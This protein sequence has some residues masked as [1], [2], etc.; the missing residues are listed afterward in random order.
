MLPMFFLTYAECRLILQHFLNICLGV[1]AQGLVSEIGPEHQRQETR[2]RRARLRHFSESPR[3][4]TDL[5]R[6]HVADRWARV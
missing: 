4:V 1:K 3:I 6:T 5:T 2:R